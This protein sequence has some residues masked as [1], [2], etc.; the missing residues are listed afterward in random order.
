MNYAKLI[1]EMEGM[2]YTDRYL[3]TCVTGRDLN[4]AINGCIALVRA[5]NEFE[6]FKEGIEKSAKVIDENYKVEWSGQIGTIFNGAGNPVG[7]FEY[8]NWNNG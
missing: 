7:S 8:T 4:K 2:K 5:A 1:D 3:D 6:I